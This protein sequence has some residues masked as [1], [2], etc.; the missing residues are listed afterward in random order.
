MYWIIEQYSDLSSSA[1]GQL[2]AFARWATVAGAGLLVVYGSLTAWRRYE[3]SP[4]GSPSE[5]ETRPSV[6]V[7]AAFTNE[8]QVLGLLEANGGRM[9][10]TRIVEATGWSK[11]KVSMLLTEM[12]SEGTISK[13]RVGRENIISRPGFEPEAARSALEPRA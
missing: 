11:S 9:R 8:E 13:L 2:P 4:D 12:E 10:Q 6:P 3:A 7:E 5:E 1:P